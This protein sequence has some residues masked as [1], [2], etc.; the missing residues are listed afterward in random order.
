MNIQPR[1]LGLYFD[2]GTAIALFYNGSLGESVKCGGG[3]TSASL[4][5]ELWKINT[6][7]MDDS[8]TKDT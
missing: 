2:T 1:R 7:N 8:V 5:A 4:S 6:D 3:K